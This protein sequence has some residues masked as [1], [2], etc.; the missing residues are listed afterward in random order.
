MQAPLAGP[1]WLGFALAGALLLIT[2]CQEATPPSAA[3]RVTV[4]HLSF[5]LPAGWQKQPPKSEM[6]AFEARIPGPGGDAE[7]AVFFFGEGK[8]GDTRSNIQRWIDQIEFAPGSDTDR[9]EFAANGMTVFWVNFNGTLKPNPMDPTIQ[10]R[11]PNS[12]LLAAVIEGPR[13]PWFFKAVGPDATLKPQRDTFLGML[14]S[15]R[16]EG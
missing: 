7:F 2:G 1:A 6:R 4:E 9:E 16:P 12:R 13:G 8:G 3:E 11:R 5:V 15:A 10:E 14:E